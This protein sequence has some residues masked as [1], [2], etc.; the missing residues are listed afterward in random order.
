[1]HFAE[2]ILKVPEI[3]TPLSVEARQEVLHNVPKLFQPDPQAMETN[4]ASVPKRLSMQGVR[5]LPA[6]KS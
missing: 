6:F 5:F 3:G 4:M 2:Q 1:V